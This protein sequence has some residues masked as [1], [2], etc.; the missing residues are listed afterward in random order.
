MK[1]QVTHWE[2]IFVIHISDKELVS[3]VHTH[4]HTHNLLK[5]NKYLP[6]M[7]NGQSI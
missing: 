2:K 4:T 3:E 6:K 5:L 7:F 1:I